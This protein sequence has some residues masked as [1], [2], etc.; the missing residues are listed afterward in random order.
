MQG[1]P[2]LHRRFIFDKSQF[3]EKPLP[4]AHARQASFTF[5]LSAVA[6]ALCAG[7]ILQNVYTGYRG[8]SNS[9]SV[10][11]SQGGETEIPEDQ[12]QL[13]MAV[14][15]PQSGYVGNLSEEQEAKLRELWAATFK[16]FNIATVED[17]GQPR[18][19]NASADDTDK[20]KS[21]KKFGIFNR[22]GEGSGDSGET[23]STSD[24]ALAAGVESMKINDVDDKY[25][26]SKDFLH[27]LANQ[28]PE[29][30]R[31]TFWNLVKHDHPD[32]LLLR[33]L[34]ARKWDVQKAL[35]MMVSTIQ[36]RLQEMHV[37]DVLVKNGEVGAM[38]DCS[39]SDATTKANGEGFMAQ[40]R[41]GK[42][43]LHG[44]DKQGR[45]MCFI[46]V[47]LH[48]QGEQSETSVE[49][50]T[51]HVIETARLLLVPPVETAVC[52]PESLH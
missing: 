46:R 22:K 21:K 4:S 10:H 44:T 8:S 34:R 51:V 14:G 18:N 45:P 6:F 2:L 33:F 5:T 48:K 19:D 30:L 26:E 32:A 52:T 42:S 7:V 39:S 43:F 15:K 23:T 25:G 31:T 50:F 24:T 27:A 11:D 16:I 3:R 9:N 49:R 47:R 17:E 12:E 41:L 20:K 40:L 1:T 28:S 37:D 36:W 38:K 35:F 13:D 29:D